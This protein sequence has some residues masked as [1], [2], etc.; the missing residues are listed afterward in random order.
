MTENI[1]IIWK[2]DLNDDCTAH[3]Q[4]LVLRVEKM[5][6]N[7]W[8]WVVYDSQSNI[9]DD[10]NSTHDQGIRYEDGNTARQAAENVAKTFIVSKLK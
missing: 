5:Q 2:G 6:R 10:S 3:W 9:I 8:W 7:L 4:G 1:P